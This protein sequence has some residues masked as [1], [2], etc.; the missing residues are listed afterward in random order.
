VTHPFIVYDIEYRDTYYA[1]ITYDEYAHE[2]FDNFK[3][4]WDVKRM[5]MNKI[6]YMHEW[7]TKGCKDSDRLNI[8]MIKEGHATFTVDKPCRE[9]QMHIRWVEH[10]HENNKTTLHKTQW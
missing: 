9:W 3:K 2:Q 10:N 4:E 7:Q 5:E 8:K 1:H 6:D